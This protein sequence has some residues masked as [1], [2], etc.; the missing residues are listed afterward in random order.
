M[1]LLCQNVEALQRASG[2]F[3]L[4]YILLTRGDSLTPFHDLQSNLPIFKVFPFDTAVQRPPE[5]FSVS[6]GH[7]V[8]Q[9]GVHGGPEEI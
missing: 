5:G 8:I 9:N 1:A 4:K 2:A 7:G 3:T 6:L